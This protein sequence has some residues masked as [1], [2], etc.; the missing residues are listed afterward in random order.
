MDSDYR[1][2][3]IPSGWTRYRCQHGRRRGAE[4]KS[5][6]FLH[7]LGTLGF[8]VGG[9]L[10]CWPRSPSPLHE[11]LCAAANRLRSPSH[12]RSNS[13]VHGRRAGC[14]AE[15]R[16]QLVTEHEPDSLVITATTGH[17]TVGRHCDHP[18]HAERGPIS[19]N[20]APLLPCCSSIPWRSTLACGHRMSSSTS[21]KWPK[22]IGLSAM[23]SPILRRADFETLPR[24]SEPE[25]QPLGRHGLSLQLV[26]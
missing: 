17:L 12:R 21:T 20:E 24:T 13:S 5:L 19:G 4:T 16:F 1:Q 22:K 15:D 11:L 10:D 8:C 2:I 23:A 7:V 6:S 25:A 14:P 18:D 3:R 9:G 26:L